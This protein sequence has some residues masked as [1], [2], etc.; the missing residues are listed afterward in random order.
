MISFYSSKRNKKLFD[1]LNYDFS[2]IKLTKNEHEPI[3][4]GWY[5]E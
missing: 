1:Y 5:E 2:A 4:L 3:L